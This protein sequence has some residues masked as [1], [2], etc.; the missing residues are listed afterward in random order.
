MLNLSHCLLKL[1]KAGDAAAE[2]SAVL[3]L[4]KRSLKAYYRR[5]VCGADVAAASHVCV[6]TRSRVRGAAP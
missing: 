2:A 1:G 3:A 6:R 5:C 4:D